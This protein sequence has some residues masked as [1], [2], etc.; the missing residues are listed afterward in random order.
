MSV[1]GSFTIPSSGEYVDP[2]TLGGNNYFTGANT[3]TQP[4]GLFALNDGPTQALT[5]GIMATGVLGDY[6]RLDDPNPD[7]DNFAG[8]CVFTKNPLVL[9]GPIAD[10][11][12]STVEYVNDKFEVTAGVQINAANTFTG[13]NN[14]S[15]GVI[16]TTLNLT[17]QYS[18]STI[19]VD[20]PL[21]F[22][23]N[24]QLGTSSFAGNLTVTSN[25]LTD[26]V[27]R[28]APY[29]SLSWDVITG[30]EI[31]TCFANPALTYYIYANYGLTARVQQ[32][33]LA[34]ATSGQKVIIACRNSSQVANIQSASGSLT[35]RFINK[36]TAS[37]PFVLARQKC[38]TMIYIGP[39]TLSG[40]LFNTCW[41]VMTL[42]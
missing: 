39:M 23:G 24:L 18:Y 22:N 6:A 8:E 16:A 7:Y 21:Q 28:T 34:V 5:K 42:L 38:V 41:Q 9:N 32:I 2:T 33:N 13:L 11:D 20:G 15:Q 40:T 4:V 35:T 25:M 31:V 3:F 36:G 29:N 17:G 19:N 30:S 14:F 10:T 12:L 37:Y 27:I 1:L 26:G